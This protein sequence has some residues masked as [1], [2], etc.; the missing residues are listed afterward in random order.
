MLYRVLGFGICVQSS[1]YDPVYLLGRIDNLDVLTTYGKCR[2]CLMTSPS[3][4]KNG[5]IAKKPEKDPSPMKPIIFCR[6]EFVDAS[7]L[8]PVSI[9]IEFKEIDVNGPI[10]SSGMRTEVFQFDVSS[11]ANPGAIVPQHHR[12][13][14][15]KNSSS[16]LFI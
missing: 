4:Y 2:M 11:S 5:L 6:Q 7:V 13:C 10:F 16:N 1:K 14:F 8:L 9:L 15:C 3:K 12:Q